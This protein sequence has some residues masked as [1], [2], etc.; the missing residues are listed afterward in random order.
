ME[1]IGWIGTGIMGNSMCAHLLD[2]GYSCCIFNRT[3]EKEKQLIAKGAVPCAS[4]AEVASR[5]DII[6]TMVGYPS[7]VQQDRKSVV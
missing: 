3:E 7:D 4:P 5:S 1:T 6:F 2:A